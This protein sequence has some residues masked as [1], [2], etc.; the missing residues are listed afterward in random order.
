MDMGMM[1]LLLLIAGGAA[2]LSK[3]CRCWIAS[4]ADLLSKNLCTFAKRN[5][6][7][8]IRQL[9]AAGADCNRRNRFGLTPLHIAASRGHREIAEVLLDAGALVDT[10]VT[11]CSG[12]GAALQIVHEVGEKH[13]AM[14][15]LGSCNVAVSNDRTDSIQA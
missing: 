4:L 7:G 14:A 6:L 10:P 8:R 9:L 2:G 15:Q 1:L 13:Q 3:E 5:D 12:N 11:I